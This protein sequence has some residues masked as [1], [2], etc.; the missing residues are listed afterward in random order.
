[1]EAF[2]R[3][4][5]MPFK[6]KLSHTISPEI[7]MIFEILLTKMRLRSYSNLANY[8]IYRS[9]CFT[10]V[11]PT[12]ET[13][14]V[15]IRES[16]NLRICDLISEMCAGEKFVNNAATARIYIQNRE[17][18]KSTSQNLEISQIIKCKNCR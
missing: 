18:K 6:E 17:R 14:R 3:C 13:K 11:K 7:R 4:A 5:P 10:V 15:V 2:E 8:F 9:E 16:A 12:E 1:M